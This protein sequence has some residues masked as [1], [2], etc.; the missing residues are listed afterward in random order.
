MGGQTIPLEMVQKVLETILK[1]DLHFYGKIILDCE[2]GQ[3]H[4]IGR[5][6]TMKRTDAER[7]LTK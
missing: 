4:Q 5:H 3:V 6:E 1:R 2:D 7:L